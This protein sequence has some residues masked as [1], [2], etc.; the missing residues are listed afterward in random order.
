VAIGVLLAKSRRMAGARSSSPEKGQS[1]GARG[2]TG[3]LGEPGSEPGDIQ[4]SALTSDE[5]DELR[6]LRREVKVLQQEREILRKAAAYC[7]QETL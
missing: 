1:R 3:P 2:G 4:R 5:R 6:R 7:A